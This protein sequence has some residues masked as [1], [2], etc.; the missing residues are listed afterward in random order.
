MPTYQNH[1]RVPK[2]CQ[3]NILQGAHICHL[4]DQG[5]GL[6]DTVQ[7]MPQTVC[8]LNKECPAHSPQWPQI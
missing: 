5:C 2:H 8:R 6:P 4:Q 7:E 1:R 3:Q